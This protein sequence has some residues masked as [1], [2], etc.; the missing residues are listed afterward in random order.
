M[1]IELEDR[2]AALTAQFQGLREVV[3]RLLAYEARR[4][5]NPSA[6]LE[7][8]SD[9]TNFRNYELAKRSPQSPRA[10]AYQEALQAEVDG[11]VSRARIIA[12]GETGPSDQKK[13]E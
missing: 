3:D 10:I 12:E 4:S 5:S 8:F 6:L 7:H 11:I 2:F 9:A 13:H 1:D